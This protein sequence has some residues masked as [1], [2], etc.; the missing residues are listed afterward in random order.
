MP[1]IPAGRLSKP[2]NLHTKVWL[3]QSRIFQLS[4]ISAENP[5]W[6]L[7]SM[8]PDQSPA[9]LTLWVK[10]PPPR[11]K[12]ERGKGCAQ[13][14]KKLIH[15]QPHGCNSENVKGPQ[16]SLLCCPVFPS[17]WAHFSFLPCTFHCCRMLQVEFST[18]VNWPR[19]I[20]HQFT[21]RIQPKYFVALGT[22]CIYSVQCFTGNMSFNLPS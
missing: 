18:T 20:L 15:P 11:A 2:R 19:S 13:E 7:P 8:S 9:E 16:V 21:R 3:Q 1:W 17:L 6:A 5:C 22:S 12:Q 14:R 10:L 4:S